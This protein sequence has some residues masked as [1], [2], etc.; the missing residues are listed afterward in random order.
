MFKAF[1]WIVRVLLF[2]FYRARV[3]GKDHLPPGAAVLCS[4][5]ST[6]SDAVF[7]IMANG[8][9]GDYGFIAKDELFH[10]P[11]LRHVIRWLH[12]F[13]VKRDQ[14][15]LSAVK[16][17]FSFL[18]QGKKLLIFPEGTRVKD[19]KSRRTGLPAEIKSGVAFFSHRA[20]VPLVPVYIPEGAKLFRNNTVRIGTPFLPAYD[21]RKPSAAD[22]AATAEEL[23]KRI[24]SLKNGVLT[25]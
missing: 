25:E 20:G 11:V 5:H 6:N 12:A 17:A 18:K 16:T 13:P 3:E 24:Y 8:P 4:N 1:Y 15:D 9:K 2:P 22:Y 21:G 7:L 23:M 19:G 10:I 14:Q